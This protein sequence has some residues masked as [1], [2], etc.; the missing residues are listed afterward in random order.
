MKPPNASLSGQRTSQAASRSN[1]EVAAFIAAIL[2]QA[3]HAADLVIAFFRASGMAG[4]NGHLDL[5]LPPQFLLTLG[6]YLQLR[7]WHDAGVIQWSHPEGLTIEDMIVAAIE[8]LKHGPQ[9]FAGSQHGTE[10]MTNMFRTWHETCSP[11]AREHLNCDLAIGWDCDQG[12][13][14][15][16]ETLAEFVW[17]HRHYA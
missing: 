3:D 2:R 8:G 10:A 4:P 11:V 12:I 14:E 16:V 15:L 6:A 7:E 9:A 13:D 5:V 1:P 17:L